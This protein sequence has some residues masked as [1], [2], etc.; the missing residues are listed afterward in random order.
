[1]INTN[2]FKYYLGLTLSPN[3]ILAKSKY[4]IK[5]LHLIELHNFESLDILKIMTIALNDID[6][7]ITPT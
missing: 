4:S 3:V 2:V 5:H 6:K 1:M 7:L